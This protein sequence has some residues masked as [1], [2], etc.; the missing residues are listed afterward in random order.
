MAEAL[1]VVSQQLRL[2]EPQLM[3]AQQQ[4]GKIQHAA[5]LAGL[6]VLAIHR[7]QGFLVDITVIINVLGAQAFI[8]MAV[9]KGLCLPGRPTGIVQLQLAH[10]PLHQP[11][12]IF[13]VQNLKILR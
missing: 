8:F 5:P 6:L 4:F 2:L 7:N 9:D 13:G 11:Q 3:T 1:P 10:D 12:L